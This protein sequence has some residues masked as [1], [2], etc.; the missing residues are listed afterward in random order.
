MASIG[1]M[2]LM[3]E[4]MFREKV[5]QILLELVAGFEEL[6]KDSR[7]LVPIAYNSL[8]PVLRSPVLIAYDSLFPVLSV[9][10]FHS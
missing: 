1:L 6:P 5:P 4:F 3:L 9:E 2:D 7:Y 10:M 8:F